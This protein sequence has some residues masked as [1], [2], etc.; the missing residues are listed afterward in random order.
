M[1]K[2][3]IAA[4]A[5]LACTGLPAQEINSYVPGEGEGVAFFLPKT[6][7]EVRVVAT[8]VTYQ[9]GEVCQ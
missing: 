6:A 5:G 4:L 1:R 3:F 2:M 7:L 8:K 9:P